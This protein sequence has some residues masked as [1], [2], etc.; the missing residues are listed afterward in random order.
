[1]NE[2]PY[3]LSQS[4][5]TDGPAE[6]FTPGADKTSALPQ[7]LLA[8]R[9]PCFATG[10]PAPGITK[11]AAVETLK[12]LAELDPVPAVSIKQ[13]WSD[14]IRDARARMPSASP[15]NSSTVSPFRLSATSVAAICAS[16]ALPSS[17][18][19]SSAPASARDN[20]SSRIKRLRKAV[21]GKSLNQIS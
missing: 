16:V 8:A 7:L 9:F 18:Q 21:T 13:A 12:V 4:S 1:M 2:M 5:Q 11:S 10:K 17:N 6:T 15:A 19:S 20:C 14:L 3:R